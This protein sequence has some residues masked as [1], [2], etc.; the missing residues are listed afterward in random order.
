MAGGLNV[1]ADL[2]GC[3]QLYEAM[4][5][6][7][8]ALECLLDKIQQLFLATIAAQIAAAGG[9]EFIATTDFPDY[10]FPEGRKGHV[11]DDI[12]ANISP[13]MYDRFSRPFHDVV[14]QQYGGGGLH[15]CG[16][17][18]CLAGYLSHRPAPRAL[19]LNYDY[20]K[21]DLPSIKQVCRKK[22]VVYLGGMPAEPA[23][24]ITVFRNIMELDGPGCD[25]HSARDRPARPEPG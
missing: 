9:E 11:S 15:N 18:P 7:P 12:S 25:R 20:S 24:A 5:E 8:D 17:N 3:N 2:L 22:G 1:A 10:W 23:A 16:P 6:N 19:D 14:F 13:A 4:Y 21:H